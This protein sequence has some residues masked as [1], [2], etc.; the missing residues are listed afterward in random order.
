MS[1]FQKV[2]E[3]MKVFTQ[4]HIKRT[5]LAVFLARL[6]V[7]IVNLAN[8]LLFIEVEKLL[9]NLLKQILK[10]YECYKK[11]MKKHFIFLQLNKKK[12][13]FDQ[14]THAGYVKNSLKMKK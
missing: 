5:F 4:K 8:Q 12:K 1:V 14:L 9:I 6:F 13:I 10:E 11:V 2:L 3:A 7:L